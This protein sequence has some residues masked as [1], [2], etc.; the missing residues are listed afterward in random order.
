MKQKIPFFAVVAVLSFSCSEPTAILLHIDSHEASPQIIEPSDVN[1][2]VITIDNKDASIE[3]DLILSGEDRLLEESLLLRPGSM[4]DQKMHIVAKGLHDG[5]ELTHGDLETSFVRGKIIEEK[6]NLDWIA[7]ACLDADLDGYGRGAACN[8]DDCDDTNGEVH[9]EALEKCNSID[10]DCDGTT[11]EED[12]LNPPNCALFSGVCRDSNQKCING[13]WQTCSISDYGDKY[14]DVE[15]DCDGFDN[16]CDGAVDEGCQCT[17]GQTRLC[18]GPDKGI[19]APGEQVCEQD[20]QEWHWSQTCDGAISPEAEICNEKDDDCDG[21]T[22]ELFDLMTDNHNCGECGH[23]CDFQHS[24]AICDNGECRILSCIEGWHD[25][26]GQIENGCEYECSP[27]N[28]S[29]EICDGKDNDCDGQ[30]DNGMSAPPCEY[31]KGVC[32]GAVRTCNGELGWGTCD[33]SADYESTESRCDGLDNDCDGAT[34]ASDDDLIIMP[35]ENQTGVCSG[36]QHAISQCTSSGW[37]PCTVE[38]YGSDYE[39]TETKCDGLDNDCDGA[40]DNQLSAPPCDLNQGVCAGTVRH[41]NGSSGWSDCDYGPNYSPTDTDCDGMDNDCNGIADD[42]T[43]DN[44]GDGYNTCTDC[45]DSD[46]YIHPGAMEICGD[47]LRQDC[48]GAPPDEGCCPPDTVLYH[49]SNGWMCAS[50]DVFGPATPANASLDCIDKGGCHM[51]PPDFN[52][53]CGML[54][55]EAFPLSTSGYFGCY[56]PERNGG[57]A[58]CDENITSPDTSCTCSTGDDFGCTQ[59]YY[60]GFHTLLPTK[61]PC[62]SDSDCGKYQ[63]CQS[64]ECIEKPH[65]IEE[66]CYDSD[67]PA[68]STCSIPGQTNNPQFL[69]GYCQ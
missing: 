41:C 21:Q 44:D 45:D 39:P 47:G 49:Y 56:H 13:Q 26:D 25:I 4:T 27:T 23:E 34:D 16:D 36:K 8:G 1:I 9:P 64:G 22:D 48:S 17:Q 35:C 31:T 69:P 19:C 57:T 62:E 68:S 14:Q 15:I 53:V 6:I 46:S 18:T 7:S 2:L 32:A 67:C 52:D 58:M 66:C 59:Y 3:K 11:D 51:K 37:Q 30:T 40:T 43:P 65:G 55:E 42:G 28:P 20:G 10:D 54:I 50:T 29:E 5:I 61:L 63:K 38:Q 24:Q 33:Y 12:D 60:C